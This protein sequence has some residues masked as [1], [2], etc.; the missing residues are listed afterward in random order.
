MFRLSSVSFIIA[1]I[2]AYLMGGAVAVNNVGKWASF[3]FFFEKWIFKN[4][5]WQ[6]AI[7]L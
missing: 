4:S 1:L 6:I 5:N 7:F 3:F 2:G